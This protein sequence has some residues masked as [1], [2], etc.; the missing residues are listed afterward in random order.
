MILRE[1]DVDLSKLFIV[2][3]KTDPE[4][5][6]ARVV[7]NNV[8]AVA[9]KFRSTGMMETVLTKWFDEITS[10]IKIMNNGAQSYEE[11]S[12]KY[13]LA[14]LASLK[15]NGLKKPVS[16]EDLTPS[17]LIAFGSLALLHP[18]LVWA[19]ADTLYYIERGKIKTVEEARLTFRNI[20]EAVAQVELLYYLALLGNSAQE[21]LEKVLM[22]KIEKMLAKGTGE[23]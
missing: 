3:T 15:S 21:L 23:K 20:V 14:P 9:A 11:M 6:E 13:I 8:V 16:P 7:L 1:R 12:K 22:P 10:S 19:A 4:N 2:D 17:D 5:N 18:A